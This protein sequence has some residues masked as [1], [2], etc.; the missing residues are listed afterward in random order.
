MYAGIGVER[1]GL[2]LQSAEA[3]RYLYV[4]AMLLAPAFA[5]AVDELRRI[6]PSA[7]VAGRVVLAASA[8]SNI[9]ALL[10]NASVWSAQSTCERHTLE[11]L[12]GDPA[13][14]GAVDATFRPLEFSPD[15][16]LFDLPLL[17]A[18]DAVV[19]RPPA[20]AA[21]ASVVAAALNPATSVCSRQ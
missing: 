13:A 14:V 8:M 10:S 19:A 9:S 5:L 16:Q 21:D 12:A 2:G 6:G 4:A 15:I 11:L 7:L 18:D 20:S 1:V 3:S 17:V